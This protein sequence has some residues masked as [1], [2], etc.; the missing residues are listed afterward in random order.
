MDDDF[1]L[2]KRSTKAYTHR[3]QTKVNAHTLTLCS[4]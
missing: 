2:K 4:W 3:T 1:V